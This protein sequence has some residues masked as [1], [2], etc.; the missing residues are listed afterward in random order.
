[1]D[2]DKEHANFRFI[3]EYDAERAAYLV[4]GKGTEVELPAGKKR[5]IEVAYE[6]SDAKPARFRVWIDGFP[7]EKGRDIPNSEIGEFSMVVDATTSTELIRL[8]RDFTMMAEFTADD[9]GGALFSKGAHLEK[10]LPDSKGLI[11]R[12]KKL[13]YDIAGVGSLEGKTELKAGEKY[14]AVIL[15]EAGKVNL[16]LNGKLEASREKFTAADPQGGVFKIGLAPLELAARFSGK[17][18]G[19]RFWGRGL[20]AEEIGNLS[21]GNAQAV[22]TPEF[23][24]SPTAKMPDAKAGEVNGHPIRLQLE[25]LGEFEGLKTQWNKLKLENAPARLQQL[26][27]TRLAEYRAKLDALNHAAM[28]AQQVRESEL[29]R[30]VAEYGQA[31]ADSDAQTA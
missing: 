28:S 2:A 31:K 22:N 19:V 6:H 29:Q 10:S 27:A 5:K 16:Y 18:S 12:N 13:V 30:L 1:M 14:T 4:L 21:K 17:I 3:A 8:D 11:V 20:N 23:N 26:R 9:K 7:V 25:I 15:S 24:W